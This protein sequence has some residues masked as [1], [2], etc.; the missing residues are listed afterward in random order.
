MGFENGQIEKRVLIQ[1]SPAIVFKALTD[2]RD[3][4]RWFC[5]R[6]SSDAREGGE[7]TAFWKSEKSGTRGKG[8]FTRL[9]P[10]TLVEITWQD[11]G[12]GPVEQP[13]HVF[14]YTIQHKRGTTEVDLLDQDGPTM[15][16]ESFSVL[17]EGW[18]YVLQDLKDFCE[19][20]ERAG[21]PRQP[22]EE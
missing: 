17:S 20:R 18:N 8:I 1:A 10:G 11:E 13:R 6:A 19:R 21:K 5:D 14:R 4:V 2:A 12:G 22:E 3:L 15:D 7:L 16:E 9:L